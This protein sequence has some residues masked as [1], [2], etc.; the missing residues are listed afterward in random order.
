MTT[1]FLKF[2]GYMYMLMEKCLVRGQAMERKCLVRGQA[3]DLR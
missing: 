2:L 1:Y 3:M